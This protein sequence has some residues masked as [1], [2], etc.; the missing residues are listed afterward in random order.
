VTGS[1]EIRVEPYAAQCEAGNVYL[2]R[3]SWNAAYIDQLCSFPNGAHD[4][5]VDGSSG[6]FSKLVRTGSFIEVSNYVQNNN[7]H[8]KHTHITPFR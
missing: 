8:G 5:M 1:K 4:D 2:V 6:A 7:R 3:G